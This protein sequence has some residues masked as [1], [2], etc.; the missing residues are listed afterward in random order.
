VHLLDCAHLCRFV[1]EKGSAEARYTAVAEDGVPPREMAE[2]IGRGLKLPVVSL[3]S[4]CADTATAGAAPNRT[5][6]DLR[7]EKRALV[8]SLKIKG[9]EVIV[10]PNIQLKED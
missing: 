3:G 8:P 7:S 5:G 10:G 2:A 1:L 9:E 6:D 4:Q